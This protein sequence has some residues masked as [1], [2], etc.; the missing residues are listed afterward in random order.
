MEGANSGQGI[1]TGEA[2]TEKGGPLRWRIWKTAWRRRSFLFRGVGGVGRS[3]SCFSELTGFHPI[4]WL[5]GLPLA[6]QTFE[7]LFLKQQLCSVN[8]SQTIQ[9]HHYLRNRKYIISWDFEMYVIAIWVSFSY[10][11]SY[12]KRKQKRLLIVFLCLCVQLPR[13]ARRG[14]QIYCSWSYRQAVMSAWYNFYEHNPGPL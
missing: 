11:I 3:A 14:C 4:I 2:R 9:D 6:N 7:I 13:E 5:L 8:K 12:L 10:L 1:N